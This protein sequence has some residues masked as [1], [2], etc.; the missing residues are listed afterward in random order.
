VLLRSFVLVR[1]Q[2][3]VIVYHS[4]GV[5]GSAA[6][7]GALGR[8][9]RLLVSHGHEEMYGPPALDVPVWAPR[10]DHAEVATSLDVAGTIDGRGMIGE[11]LEVLPTPGHTPGSTAFLWDDGAHRFL[12]TGDSVWIE[13]GEWRAVL[14]DPDARRTYLDSL[15]LVRELDFDVLVPW[16]VTDGDPPFGVVTG[17]S[18]IRERI[19]AIVERLEAGGDG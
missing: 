15:A 16:G 11:D 4:P 5:S 12:F 10:G 14:L 8:P 19:D 7:I 6:A 1:P 3:N 17:R 18:E 13:R 2:G 9:S